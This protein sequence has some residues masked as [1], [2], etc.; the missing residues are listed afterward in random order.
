M[1]KLHSQTPPKSD[2]A[3]L[4]AIEERVCECILGKEH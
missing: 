4:G 2:N 1:K 3:A